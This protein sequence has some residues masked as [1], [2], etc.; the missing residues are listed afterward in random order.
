M[1]IYIDQVSYIEKH[2]LSVH[3]PKF[4]FTI[5]YEC[6]Y[7]YFRYTYIFDTYIH[8]YAQQ[9]TIT[10]LCK[11]VCLIKFFFFI[12]FYYHCNIHSYAYS[13]V[14]VTVCCLCISDCCMHQQQRHS[15]KM[16]IM[17]NCQKICY[18]SIFFLQ[19]FF[20]HFN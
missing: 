20:L 2:F 17:C 4:S 5:I 12:R 13:L 14:S 9:S 11:R 10:Y 6:I 18:E 1:R 7:E 16:Q 15:S 8:I 19:S 3:K